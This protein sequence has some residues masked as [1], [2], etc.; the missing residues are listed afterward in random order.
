MDT[1]GQVALSSL[2][3]S[4]FSHNTW[5]AG[6]VN[7]WKGVERMQQIWHGTLWAWIQVLLTINRPSVMVWVFHRAQQEADHKT[8]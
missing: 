1:Q 2:S 5:P 3:P 6:T 7:T 8:P 4:L